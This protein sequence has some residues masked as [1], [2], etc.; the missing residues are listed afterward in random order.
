MLAAIADPEGFQW[1]P[2]V[3]WTRPYIWN[4]GLSPTHFHWT[5]LDFAGSIL[6]LVPPAAINLHRIL[7]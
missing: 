1:K 5:P 4:V 7:L 3:L 2:M 6:K